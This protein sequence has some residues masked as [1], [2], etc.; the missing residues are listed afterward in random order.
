MKRGFAGIL[1]VGF[2]KFVQHAAPVECSV[3]AQQQRTVINHAAHGISHAEAV[4]VGGQLGQFQFAFKA[5]V[6]IKNQHVIGFVFCVF[7]RLIAVV[8]KILPTIMM[9][10]ACDALCIEKAADHA[11]GIIGRAGVTDDVVVKFDVVGDV[12]QCFFDNCRFVFDNHI[13]ADGLGH[14]Q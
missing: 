9:N 3:I 10:L 1:F 12:G 4:T 7:Q 11:G 6:R 2:N 5:V 8:C 14:F 13:Q